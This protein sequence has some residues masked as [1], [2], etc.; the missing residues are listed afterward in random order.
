MRLNDNLV[1]VLE[2]CVMW[3]H[4]RWLGDAL[5]KNRYMFFLFFEV[6]FKP[7]VGFCLW[8]K[9]LRASKARWPTLKS[10]KHY[11]LPKKKVLQKTGKNRCIRPLRWLGVRRIEVLRLRGLLAIRGSPRTESLWTSLKRHFLALGRSA[12]KVV[13]C[14]V[15][16]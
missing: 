16:V 14:I 4:P 9:G 12:S 10:S 13:T 5:K 3:A 6:R 8:H 15:A 2:V 1:Y 7:L 11:S